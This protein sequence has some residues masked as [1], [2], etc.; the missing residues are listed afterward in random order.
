MSA[1]RRAK[2]EAAASRS[3]WH[4]GP[5]AEDFPL[6]FNGLALLRNRNESQAAIITLRI[7]YS[8]GSEFP[9]YGRHLRASGSV[10]L[11]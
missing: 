3:C 7:M 1:G 2:C 5:A 9:C 6:R 10:W 4:I 11:A 8:K